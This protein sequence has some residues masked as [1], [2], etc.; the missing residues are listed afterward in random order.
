MSQKDSWPAV[1]RKLMRDLARA[2]LGFRMIEE[3][4]R[5]LVAVSG[6][7]DS[8]ALHHLLQRLACRAPVRFSLV[9]V[10]VDQG[11]PGHDPTPLVEYLRG[12][13]AEVHLIRDATYP[14]VER[15]TPPGK[16]Y[17]SLCSR[18]RRAILY[19]V[20]GE[21]G[22][23]KV[24][25]GHHRNDTIVTLLLNL[26][27]SGQLKAMPP[28]LLAEDGKNVVIRPLL[29][30]DEEMLRELA[31][32]YR[33]PILPCNLCGSQPDLERQAMGRLLAELEQRHPGAKASMLAALANVR[34][35]HLLDSGLWQKLGLP[36][37]SEV[38]GE[39]EGSDPARGWDFGDE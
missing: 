13:G 32:H 8:Y 21:L 7:K 24:A 38:R 37:A 15:M 9:A 28:K 36:L 12:Q 19:R 4:D 29:F 3:G 1:E 23:T 39:D 26:T 5:I 11:Q 35:T 10:H 14:I 17:C 31:G 20:A 27:F 2:V 25:L 16:P 18:L 34:P 30:C 6:G 33:F 22:C